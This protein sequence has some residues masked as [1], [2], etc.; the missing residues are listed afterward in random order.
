MKNIIL[1]IF[2][3]LLFSTTLNAQKNKQPRNKITATVSFRYSVGPLVV[4]HQEAKLTFEKD[5]KTLKSIETDNLL[6]LWDDKAQ[7]FVLDA[8]TLNGET[9]SDI[10]LRAKEGFDYATRNIP[11]MMYHLNDSRL[12]VF[13]FYERH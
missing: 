8:Y 3:L 4:H 7:T 2:T 6:L 13:I 5:G 11:N 9:E 12:M 1:G 10:A